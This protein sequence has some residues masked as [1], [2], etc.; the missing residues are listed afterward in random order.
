MSTCEKLPI[1]VF[2]PLESD[3][4][5]MIAADLST[6]QK[7]LYNIC[8][9]I[10]KGFC[11]VPLSRRNPGALSHSRWLTAANRLLRLYVSTMDPSAKLIIVVTYIVKV[12]TP[13][14]F[15]IKSNPSCKDGARHLLQTIYK[16][17]YLSKELRAVIDPV[18]QR[19]GYFAHPESVLLSMLTDDRKYIRE[20]ALHCIIRARSEQYGLR[21]FC[22]PKI[23]FTAKDYIDLIHWQNT[24]ISE[25][26]ILTN[27]SVT[28]LEMF[29]ASGDVPVV[30]FAKYPCH[31]QSVERCV[32]LVTSASAAVSGVKARDGFI[33]VRLESRQLMPNFNN[34]A[35]YRL[36]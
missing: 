28:D 31:T 17:R 30:D 32:K 12:Y 1:V 24:A 36:A 20:L 19:N 34:K 11:L 10:S 3:L 23:N 27:T 5:P 18:I 13:M 33:R 6:D 26:P 16:L 4:P 35:E 25:P 15:V 2:T 14:W 7:Y 9:A 21:T 22:I 8:D 29:V